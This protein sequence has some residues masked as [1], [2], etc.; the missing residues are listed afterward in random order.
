MRK[1]LI[2]LCLGIICLT[3]S[4]LY[5]HSPEKVVL[6]YDQNSQLLT[7]ETAHSVSNPDRHFVNRIEVSL[8]GKVIIDKEPARQ[9]ESGL[10][11]VYPLANVKSGD[12]I[13]A[14]AFCSKGGDQSGQI[15]IT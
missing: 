5:A 14:T 2:V 4:R 11:E 12:I 10:T 7:V 9:N 3:A 13:K 6:S 8:N 1:I 15:Q